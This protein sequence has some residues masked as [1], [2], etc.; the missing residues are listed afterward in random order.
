MRRGTV[1]NAGDFRVGPQG[2]SPNVACLPDLSGGRRGHVPGEREK[3]AVEDRDGTHQTP[4]QVE[5]GAGDFAA[6]RG[7]AGINLAIKALFGFLYILSEK[8][9]LGPERIVATDNIGPEKI[10]LGVK[11]FSD[12]IDL[13]V[14]LGLDATDILPDKIDVFPD[15]LD[16][17][18]DQFE[19]GLCGD[20]A[21]NASVDG[22]RDGFG[23]FL[24]DACVAKA[25]NFG[26]CVER[27][28]GHVWSL[29]ILSKDIDHSRPDCQRPRQ[30]VGGKG[31]GCFTC[32]S[33]GKP[34][35]EPE[36]SPLFVT[37]SGGA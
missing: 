9:D 3:E 6:Q 24:F 19:V 7:R 36:A 8:I 4:G 1:L 14:K 13:A 34:L 25:L 28:L 37:A 30:C 32:G 27:C 10:D 29:L 26:D 20:P 15:Q 18:P 23:L 5:L 16:V 33:A 2:L 21:C 35:F 11:P 12:S 17:F 31:S 22:Q